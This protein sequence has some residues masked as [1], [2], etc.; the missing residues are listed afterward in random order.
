MLPTVSQLDEFHARRG[1]ADWLEADTS[2]KSPAIYKASDLI[3]ATYRVDGHE[4]D[5]RVV[6]AIMLLAPDMLGSA[7]RVRAAD[8]AVLSTEDG[9]GDGAF[10]EKRT[11]AKP[12]DDP[13]PL[14]TALLADFG[15]RVGAAGGNSLKVVRVIRGY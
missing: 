6:T 15:K 1:N 12:T 14:I 13:Y 8:Q 7:L 10:L 2:D 4:G 5:P 3:T 9:V 11:Y